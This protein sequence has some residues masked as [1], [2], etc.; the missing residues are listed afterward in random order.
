M[1]WNFFC[2]VNYFDHFFRLISLCKVIWCRISKFD[3]KVITQRNLFDQSPL[4]LVGIFWCPLAHHQSCFGPPLFQDE[5]HVHLQTPC[6]G[7]YFAL[8][9]LNYHLVIEIVQL[10][11]SFVFIRNFKFLS[12]DHGTLWLFRRAKNKLS[13]TNIKEDLKLMIINL[14]KLAFILKSLILQ[15]DCWYVLGLPFMMI[16]F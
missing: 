11:F 15:K 13:P 16:F 5:A 8:I 6:E 12:R 2:I 9:L 14:K 4:L 7:A 3:I 1:I 10:T